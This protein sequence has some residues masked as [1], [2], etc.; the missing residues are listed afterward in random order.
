VTLEFSTQALLSTNI[1]IQSI[2][3]DNIPF[4]HQFTTQIHKKRDYKELLTNVHK[5]VIKKSWRKKQIQKLEQENCHIKLN[6]KEIT[7][8][9]NE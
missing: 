9:F 5:I 6:T 7:Y 3:A 2:A 8:M 1:L 4:I